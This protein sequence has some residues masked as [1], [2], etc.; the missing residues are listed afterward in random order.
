[1]KIK[2]N[3]FFDNKHFIIHDVKTINKARLEYFMK[4]ETVLSHKMK[5]NITY[6]YLKIIRDVYYI[7][8]ILMYIESSDF[9]IENRV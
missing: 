2:P 4:I 5:K 6:I 3:L 9:K 7:L 8:H 1:M